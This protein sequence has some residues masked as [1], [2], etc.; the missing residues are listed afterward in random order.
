MSDRWNVEKALT[1]YDQQPWLRGCNF[2][3]STAINQIEMWSASTFDPETIDR[4]LGW[5]ARIGFNA[6]RVYLHDLPWLEDRDGFFTRIDAYL[7][8]ADRH[9]IQTLLV[10]FDDCWHEPVAGVQPA[11]RRGVHNSGWARCPGRQKLLDRTCWGQLEDYVG[12][13]VGS[14]GDDRRVLGWDI[15]NEVTNV[16]MPSLN[17]SGDDL[18]EA[19]AQ[20]ERDREAQTV[21]ATELA[22]A[23]FGWARTVAP[24]QPLTAGIYMKN[25]DLNPQLIELSD[26]VSF[27]HY[28]SLEALERLIS[29]LQKYD[30]PILCTEYLNRRGGSLFQTHM[31]VFKREKIGCFNWGL[32][33]GK[34]QTKFAWTDAPGSPE[35]SIWFHDILRVDGSPY[36]VVETELIGK[37]TSK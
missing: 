3:P 10:L 35:P 24:S 28:G 6:M 14:F 30:R 11:P 9:G 17:L 34:T 36:D 29:K 18:R 15:Y 19:E 2:I 5:A 12:D 21:A 7:K 22:I 25:D 16:A 4:E 13:V 32:V 20:S 1:W 31:P 26:I 37:M 33:D 8:I 23:A 27:H